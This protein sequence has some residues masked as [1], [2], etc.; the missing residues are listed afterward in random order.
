MEIEKRN[1]FI[2][3]NEESI[4]SDQIQAPVKSQVKWKSFLRL[5]IRN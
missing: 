4:Q 2:R 5:A 3:I 1:S